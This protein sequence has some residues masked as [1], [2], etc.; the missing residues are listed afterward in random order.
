MKN[1]EH[2]K[3]P[4]CGAKQKPE[5]NIAKSG[6]I[7]I[8][9][10]KE[11]D[12]AAP[13]KSWF[14]AVEDALGYKLFFWQKT[15]IEIG[16]FRCYGETTAKILRELSKVNEPPLDLVKYRNRG[17]RERWFCEELLRIKNALDAAG[18]PTREVLLT[19]RE[20]QEYLRRKAAV[21]SLTT[22]QPGELEGLRA[23]GRFWDI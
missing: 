15:F 16:V 18:V 9:P 8:N 10:Y 2:K 6:F 11:Y 22:R 13:L 1:K 17:H 4:F 23:M 3:C 20:E 7:K 19:V 21:E 12:F 5:N 14:A